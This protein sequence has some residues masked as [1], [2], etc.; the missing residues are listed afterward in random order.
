MIKRID[1][2]GRILSIY[3]DE[4]TRSCLCLQARTLLTDVLHTGHPDTVLFHCYDEE[5]FSGERPARR[6]CYHLQLL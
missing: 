1:F 2:Q 4:V 5:G 3:F 6:S